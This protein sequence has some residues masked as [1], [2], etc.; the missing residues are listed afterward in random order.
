M[1]LDV[2]SVYGTSGA[3]TIDESFSRKSALV[4]AGF[5]NDVN[6]EVLIIAFGPPNISDGFLE[7]KHKLSG[8]LPPPPEL[9]D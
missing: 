4:G 6:G 2:G 3:S 8:A 5:K 9:I 1:L 7:F